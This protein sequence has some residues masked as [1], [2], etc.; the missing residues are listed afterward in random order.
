MKGKGRGRKIDGFTLFQR[1]GS[2]QWTLAYQVEPGKWSQHR[3]PADITAKSAARAYALAWL[4]EQRTALRLPQRGGAYTVRGALPLW[5][6]LREANPRVRRSTIADNKGHFK[7]HI[8]PALGDASIDTITA[9]LV[10]EWLHTMAKKGRAAR[11]VHHALSSLSSFLDDAIT[12]GWTRLQANPC[13]L[14]AV[15]RSL[16]EAL[17]EQKP[18]VTLE[19]AIALLSSD[20]PPERILRY[21]IAFVTGMRDGEIAG[22]S[23]DDLELGAEIPTWHVRQAC[24]IRGEDGFAS[25]SSPKTHGSVRRVPLPPPLADALTWWRDGGC[26]MHTG[27]APT[28][29]GPVFPSPITG[30]HWRPRSA[31]WLRH[32]LAAAGLPTDVAGT[33][34]DFHATRRSFATWLDEV[35]VAQHM[36]GRLMGHRDKG[37]TAEAY[38]G[39]V[40]RRLYEAACQNPLCARDC[41]ERITEKLKPEPDQQL[42]PVAQWIEQRFPNASADEASSAGSAD[43]D[44][45]AAAYDALADGH[46]TSEARR[47][48]SAAQRSH[49]ARPARKVDPERVARHLER[50]LAHALDRTVDAAT[51]RKRM[52]AGLKAAAKEMGE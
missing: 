27:C 7:N 43:S 48:M 18:H 6:A 31:K 30:M 47:I 11:T 37:V 26:E 8:L 14:D 52:T 42:A 46:A 23:W 25:L 39:R 17:P 5:L 2:K 22:G 15:R 9:A 3:V 4:A 40:L 12:E 28:Q 19:Q 10:R 20:A 34:I 13:R 44:A 41:A 21:L 24:A 32:D 1:A 50:T 45:T 29:T 33:P 35:G 36:I 51:R 38:T 16:P 49:K